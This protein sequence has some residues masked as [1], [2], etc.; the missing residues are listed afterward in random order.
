MFFYCENCLRI[1]N[2]SAPLLNKPKFR[3]GEVLEYF[4]LDS[5]RNEQ[6]NLPSSPVLAYA[7]SFS[8][9]QTYISRLL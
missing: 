4:C 3:L 1:V 8:Y 2:G 7:K 5:I 6:G 9:Q